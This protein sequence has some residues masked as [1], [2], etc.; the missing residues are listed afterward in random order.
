MSALYLIFFITVCAD[1]CGGPLGFG[2]VV[3][4]PAYAVA[5]LNLSSDCAGLSGSLSGTAPKFLKLLRSCFLVI[6]AGCP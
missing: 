5:G 4:A 3:G 1:R 2:A 6:L